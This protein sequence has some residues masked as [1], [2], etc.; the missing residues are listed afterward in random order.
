[1]LRPHWCLLILLALPCVASAE[2]ISVPFGLDI[3]SAGEST[4]ASADAEPALDLTFEPSSSAVP[5]RPAAP[6]LPGA[7]AAAPAPKAPFSVG[8]DIRTRHEIGDEKRQQASDETPLAS[9]VADKMKRST[10][11]LKGTYRF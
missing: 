5:R 11:G 2:P 10:F 4:D 3:A 1:V 7:A 9:E 8:L 6:K